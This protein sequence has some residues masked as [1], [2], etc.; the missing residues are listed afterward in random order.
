MPSPKDEAVKIL[1]AL[2]D[3]VG[4]TGG[5]LPH[6]EV[7]AI[8]GIDA[9][10]EMKEAGFPG[11]GELEWGGY[12]LKFLLQKLCGDELSGQVAPHD[13]LHKRHFV[14][15]DYVWDAHLSAED[16]DE[17]ILGAVD[18][19]TDII[20]TNGGIG[21]FV[22]D[23]VFHKDDTGEFKRFQEDLKGGISEYEIKRE[24][25]GRPS[26]PRKEAFMIKKVFGYFFTLAD[27]Q[28]GLK[29]R[30]AK[31]SFQRTMRNSNDQPR[32]GKYSI[33]INSI[34]DKYLLFVKNFNED[35]EEFK[36]IY[37][38]FG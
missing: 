16:K 19:Y 21:V 25:E 36:E 12:Y 26:Q 38:E 6:R 2:F 28:E 3:E 8:T 10:L 30:W 31:D 34:P 17:V 1:D 35:A 18:E 14:K 33:K 11:W 4:A 5:Q 15:G 29:N 22:V 32:N 24:L 20:K 9:L 13:L 27:L 37:P 7:P 23:T